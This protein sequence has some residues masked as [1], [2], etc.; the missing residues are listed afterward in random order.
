MGR[1]GSFFGGIRSS[2][3]SQEGRRL[4]VRVEADEELAKAIQ[5]LESAVKI[6]TK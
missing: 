6:Q 3:V 4:K 5:E 2:G 1:S